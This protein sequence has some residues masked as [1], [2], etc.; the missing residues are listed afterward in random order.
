MDLRSRRDVIKTLLFGAVAGFTPL[1][2]AISCAGKERKYRDFEPAYL[3]LHK[4]GELKKRGKKLWESMESCELCPR[5]CGVNKLKGEKGICQ[6]N[7]QLEVYAF[8][9][10]F[11]EEKPLVGDGGSGTGQDRVPERAGHS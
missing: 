1:F 6:A 9:A 10:H 5:M 11:G 3:K 4:S 7:S 8:H 2:S